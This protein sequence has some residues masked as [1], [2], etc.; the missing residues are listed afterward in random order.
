MADA[1]EHLSLLCRIQQGQKHNPCS[2]T[3]DCHPDNP[4]PC[5]CYCHEPK[6]QIRASVLYEEAYLAEHEDPD[7]WL[8]E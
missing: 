3:C 8:N 7:V 2:G 6:G 1:V 4:Q 5:E